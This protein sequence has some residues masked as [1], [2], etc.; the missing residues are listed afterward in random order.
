MT[1][2]Q[3]VCPPENKKQKVGHRGN[4]TSKKK[5]ETNSDIFQSVQEHNSEL[6]GL[7]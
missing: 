6:E 1:T 4:L 5:S 3:N 2:A 7:K